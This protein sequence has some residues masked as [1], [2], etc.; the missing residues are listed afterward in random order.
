[1][2]SVANGVACGDGVGLLGGFSQPKTACE[3]TREGQIA[4][5]LLF[6][7]QAHAFGHYPWRKQSCRRRSLWQQWLADRRRHHVQRRVR[8]W[9][10]A[11][12]DDFC[13]RILLSRGSA[14]PGIL[15][16]F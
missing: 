16:G 14:A 15:V 11:K 3:D 12:R 4:L 7:I 8:H 9:P 6:A 5:E 10:F 13:G 1:M 2:L